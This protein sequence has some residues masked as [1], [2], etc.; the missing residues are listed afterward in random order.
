M[1]D[2]EK[3]NEKDK[4]E[5]EKGAGNMPLTKEAAKSRDSKSSK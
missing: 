2:K 4:K 5:K 3:K 1:A